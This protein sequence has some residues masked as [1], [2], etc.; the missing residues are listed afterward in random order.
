[1]AGI[2]QY[3][4]TKKIYFVIFVLKCSQK[5]VP[6]SCFFMY[7]W[8]L[9]SIAANCYAPYHQNITSQTRIVLETTSRIHLCYQL[10]RTFWRSHDVQLNC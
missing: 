10:F 1:M 3:R 7:Y 9:N 4:K 6:Y 2:K 8:H 5:H